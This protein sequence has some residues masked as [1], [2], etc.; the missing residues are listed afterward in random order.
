MKTTPSILK[1]FFKSQISS[2]IATCSDFAMFWVS[3]NLLSIWYAFGSAMGAFTGGLVHFTLGRYWS[4]LASSGQFSAQAGRYFVVALGSL[5]L[6][7]VGIYIFVEF[8]SLQEWP[9]KI[10]ISLMVGFF[11]NFPLHRYYVFSVKVRNEAKSR[12]FDDAV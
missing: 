9:S 6:N 1:S 8:F 4:F 5:L 11:F 12:F 7:A 2:F 10:G 3:F